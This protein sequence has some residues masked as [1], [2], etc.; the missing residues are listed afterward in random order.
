M[1]L[2]IYKYEDLVI[3]LILLCN[4]DSIFKWRDHW[5]QAIYF[6][7]NLLNFN[8]GEKFYVDCNHDEYSLWF[9]VWDE[10]AGKILAEK[11][12]NLSIEN[13]LNENAEER[14]L[15][16]T[17]VSRSRLSQLNLTSNNDLFVRLLKKVNTFLN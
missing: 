1:I 2:Q 9:D 16:A 10:Q 17:I 13:F 14:T 7:K 15:G 3:F 5:M 6:P 12:K 4:Y 8:K 11:T